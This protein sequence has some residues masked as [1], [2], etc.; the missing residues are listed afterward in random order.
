MILYHGTN[1]DIKQIDL[2][3]CR[4]SRTLEDQKKNSD[5]IQREI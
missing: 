1:K 2:N 4:C 3:L 5:F